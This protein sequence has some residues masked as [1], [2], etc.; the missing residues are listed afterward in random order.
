MTF[1][2]NVYKYLLKYVEC[3]NCK[4]LEKRQFSLISGLIF[5][6]IFTLKNC[7]RTFFT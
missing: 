1:S 7:D 6:F 3:S 5:S 2:A 4:Y